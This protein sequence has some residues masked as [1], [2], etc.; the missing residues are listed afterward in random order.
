M[1]VGVLASHRGSILQ[2]LID[3]NVDVALVISNNRDSS[4]LQRA[5]RHEIPFRHLSGRTHE[6]VAGL[7]I[8]IRDALCEHDIDLVFFAGY[9]KKLGPKTL[10][11]FKNRILNT[12][13]SLLPNMV[14][15]ECT[16]TGSMRR[17]SP[18]GK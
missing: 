14:E 1:N 4:A 12:H 5:K 13:P 7:D 18:P 10:A 9:L 2:A 15:R 3:A 16:A 6:T 17:C 8:T 11:A